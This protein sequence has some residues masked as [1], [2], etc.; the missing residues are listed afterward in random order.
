M[1]ETRENPMPN[2]AA[3][4]AMTIRGPSRSLRKP[5]S[6]LRDPMKKNIKDPAPDIKAATGRG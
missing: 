3:V 4:K 6:A 1:V 2:N 5:I